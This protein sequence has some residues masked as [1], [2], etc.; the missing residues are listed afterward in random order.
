[1]RDLQ[2]SGHISK[3]VAM[4]YIAAAAAGNPS[5]ENRAVCGWDVEFVD[6][7]PCQKEHHTE[8]LAR[9]VSCNQER[10]LVAVAYVSQ[11]DN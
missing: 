10:T 4:E 3:S 11:T 8:R 9:V 6:V 5:F 7:K 1:M 2:T